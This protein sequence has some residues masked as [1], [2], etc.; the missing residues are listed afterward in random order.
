MP[1][2]LHSDDASLDPEVG[3]DG[4]RS[5][6]LDEATIGPRDGA[7]KTVVV[8]MSG[9]VDS[10]VTA[11]VMRERGYRV[12]GMNLRLFSPEDPEHQV[13]PCCGIA[14]LDDARATCAT[15]GV[16]F[17]AID[18]ESEFGEAVVDTFVSEYAA[19]RT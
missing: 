6:P 17:Y 9:G 19:G 10:A 1:T 8:A 5:D 12:I 2:T 7:G 14:A 13:N 16:P 15:I 3:D 18:M 11:L 4:A